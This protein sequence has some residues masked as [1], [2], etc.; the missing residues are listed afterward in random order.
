[1][2]AQERCFTRIDRLPLIRFNITAELKKWLRV[3]ED[4]IDFSMANPD[5]ATPPHIVGKTLHCRPAARYARATPPPAV[6]SPRAAPFRAGTVIAITLR[7]I[8]ESE[9]IVTIGQRGA[10]ASDGRRWI[11]WR[12]GAL[13]PNQAYSDPFMARV[14][15]GAQVRS[16]LAGGRR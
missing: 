1:M 6:F 8:R 12:H 5:G 13:V 14:I 3:G 15:A 16:V 7:S 10:G 2:T 4:I 11:K 9:A